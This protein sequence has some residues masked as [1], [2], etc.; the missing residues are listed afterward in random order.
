MQPHEGLNV[1]DSAL[2]SPER[3]LL[4]YNNATLEHNPSASL[5]IATNICTEPSLLGIVTMAPFGKSNGTALV[6][7]KGF[8]EPCSDENNHQTESGTIF[9]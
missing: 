5:K 8:Q 4:P 3:L 6:Q 2:N 9:Y 1:H 7:T